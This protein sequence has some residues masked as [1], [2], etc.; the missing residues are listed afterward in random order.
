MGF[1]GRGGRQQ[2]WLT[3][4]DREVY[5]NI[6]LKAPLFPLNCL[7]TQGVAYSRRGPAGDPTFDSAGFKN[8]VYAFFGSGTGLQELYLQ[9]GKLTAEDWSVLA[10]AA[11][12]SRANA[13]VLVDT[14]WVGGDPGRGEVYGYASWNPRH[15]IIM[16]RNPQDRP[17]AFRLD[18][19]RALELP[20]DSPT[21]YLL[22][23][24]WHEHSASQTIPVKA[25]APQTIQLL[26]F[27]ILL[28][29]ATPE[30]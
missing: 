13:P 21:S 29:E 15:S 24:P 12:W 16:L 14:H 17:Q 26:P 1:T 18:I 11:Q 6:V 23:S 2:Q 3:Y 22:K 10:Q 7:M 5:H 8:D 19:G 4:R 30:S 20:S 25:G 9:P 27:G 28:F